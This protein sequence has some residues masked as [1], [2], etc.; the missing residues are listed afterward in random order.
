MT[1]PNGFTN[2][3]I[4]VN[5]TKTMEENFRVVHVDL[6]DLAA[7]LDKID[8]HGSIGTKAELL[9]HESRIRGLERYRYAMPSVGLI[10]GIAGII[11]G[12]VAVFGGRA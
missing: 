3:E 1:D 11:A 2:K 10:A 6:R 4:L 12:L 8:R 7:K 5:L 9:D